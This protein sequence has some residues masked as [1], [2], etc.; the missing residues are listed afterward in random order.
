M[1]RPKLTL[2]LHFLGLSVIINTKR[3][4]ID[5]S[6]SVQSRSMNKPDL[7]E[8]DIFPGLRSDQQHARSDLWL[9]GVTASHP[10]VARELP[11]DR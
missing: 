6:L 11:C 4:D 5:V 10:K 1:S 3:P 7:L 8:R 9:N 2:Y